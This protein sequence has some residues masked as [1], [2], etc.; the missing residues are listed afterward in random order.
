MFRT[1]MR[2]FI[3]RGSP[4]GIEAVVDQQLEAAEE[5]AAPNSSPSWNPKSTSAAR[6]RV[7]QRSS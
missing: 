5:I 3:Q 1:K 2:S 7:K 4:V 6:K